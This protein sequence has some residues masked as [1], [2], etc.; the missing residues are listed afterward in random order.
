LTWTIIH[1]DLTFAMTRCSLLAFLLVAMT[2]AITNAAGNDDHSAK[3]YLPACRSFVNR[4]VSA[5]PFR[6]GQCV[7]IIE[8]L[9]VTASDLD[10]K[11]FVV[12][13]SCAPNDGT[14]S[15]MATVVVHW[16]DQ[17]PAEWHRDFRSLALLA[18][19]DAWPCN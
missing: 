16:L 8:G 7:G 15:Q 11:L 10:P 19:H 2:G 5:D 4:D 9:A 12:S 17:H 3:Y 6:Q 13:R 1:V 14:L 18:L